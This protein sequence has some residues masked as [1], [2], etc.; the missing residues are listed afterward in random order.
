[1]ATITKYNLWQK[2]QL[3]GAAVIDWDTDTIKVALATSTYTP[4]ATT[5]DFF[6]DITNEVTGTNYTAG[7]ATIATIAVT[8]SAGVST[9]DGADVTWS[10][11]GA[12]FA[13]ARYGIIY[14]DTGVPGTSPL[15]GYIDFTTDKGN[16]D[17]DL[18]LQWAGTGIFTQS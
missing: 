6:A 3:N 7:G 8:E 5:H 9:V 4:S 1:M 18:S 2:N 11:S 13:N 17:G 16:V 12:G 10:Q 15:M 14:K